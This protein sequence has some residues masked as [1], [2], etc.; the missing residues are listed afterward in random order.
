MLELF[1]PL[2]REIKSKKF[3]CFISKVE[4]PIRVKTCGKRCFQFIFQLIKIKLQRASR[5]L[6]LEFNDVTIMTSTI[7]RGHENEEKD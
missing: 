1:R 3:K 2:F 4:D 5:L 7:L 6:S